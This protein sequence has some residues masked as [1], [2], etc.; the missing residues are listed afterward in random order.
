MGA[1]LAGS[2]DSYSADWLGNEKAALKVARLV[3]RKV[4]TMV[5]SL[6]ELSVV[7]KDSE[8]AVSRV[9]RMVVE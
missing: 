2:M 4:G 8:S 1:M 7:W 5:A 6:V 3:Q 9:D